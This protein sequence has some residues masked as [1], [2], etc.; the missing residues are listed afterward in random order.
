VAQPGPQCEHFSRWL[1]SDERSEE[2]VET[3]ALDFDT[4]LA[5]LLNRRE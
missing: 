3:K 2:R 4:A 5:R 1:S